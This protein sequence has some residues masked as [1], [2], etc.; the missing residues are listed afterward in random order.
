MPCSQTPVSP[1]LLTFEDGRR[2]GEL[3]FPTAFTSTPWRPVGASIH[4]MVTV[5]PPRGAR[6]L[7]SA[8]PNASALTMTS[9]YGAQSHGLFTRYLRLT[10]V[11][12]AFAL[13]GPSKT[14]LQ[15][16]VNLDWAGLI[17]R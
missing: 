1:L 10:A 14:R 17:S 5:S 6:L 11:L 13:V 12:R 8:I 4:I 3:L 2:C 9:D 15:L 7:P 16:V